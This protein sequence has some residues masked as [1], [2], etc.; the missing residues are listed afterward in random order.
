[1]RQIVICSLLCAFC[2]SC[3]GPEIEYENV[4]EVINTIKRTEMYM[5]KIPVIPTTANT[6]ATFGLDTDGHIGVSWSTYNYNPEDTTYEGHINSQKMV[7]TCRTFPGLTV[8]EWQD[9]KKQLMSM[10]DMRICFSE[11]TYY[12]DGVFQ[13]FNYYYSVPDCLYC[14]NYYIA[15]LTDAIVKTEDFKRRFKVID[16]KGD[17]YLLQR[18][19]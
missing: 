10:R 18:W 13:F 7:D 11:N 2:M 5:K 6:Y 8:D 4:D 1:M 16:K 12:N 9:L 14:D 19:W 17:L 15:V 3:G